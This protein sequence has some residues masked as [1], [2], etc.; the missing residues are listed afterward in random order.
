[1]YVCKHIRINMCIYPHLGTYIHIHSTITWAILASR[2]FRCICV[3]V[4]A[5]V[6]A[7]ILCAIDHTHLRTHIGT[8]NLIPCANFVRCANSQNSAG[9][10]LQ[11]E[12]IC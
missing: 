6:Y 1:M 10:T 11:I 5:Y 3:Y 2:I 9:H 8:K 7:Y 12:K 4:S